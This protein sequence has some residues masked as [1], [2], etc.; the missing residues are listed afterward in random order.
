MAYQHHIVDSR[1]LA[2]DRLE[3]AVQVGK[4]SLDTS[5]Y[6]AAGA[7]RINTRVRWNGAETTI[8]SDNGGDPL[9]K[10]EG[11]AWVAKKGAIVMGMRINKP[12]RNV[13]TLAVD[14]KFCRSGCAHSFNAAILNFYVGVEGGTASAV[15]Y[16]DVPDADI[17]HAGLSSVRFQMSVCQSLLENALLGHV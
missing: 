2:H 7:G 4:P 8:A 6:A 17:C 16:L 15:E 14:F 12:W 1:L 11:H 9:G 5:Q 3:I 10:L 13:S